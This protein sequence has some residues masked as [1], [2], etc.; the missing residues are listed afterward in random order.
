VVMNRAVANAGRGT[1]DTGTPVGAVDASK[2]CRDHATTL[3]SRP[4]P[5][6]RFDIVFR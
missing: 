5:R 2:G 1:D 4:S 6:W 3:Q